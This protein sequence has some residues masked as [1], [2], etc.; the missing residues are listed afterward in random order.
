MLS[1]LCIG[2]W[3]YL[4]AVYLQCLFRSHPYFHYQ[5]F[6]MF[7]T[8]ELIVSMCTYASVIWG[9][10]LPVYS[11]RHSLIEF[12]SVST[13][14]H[15]DN[16]W[17]FVMLKSIGYFLYYIFSIFFCYLTEVYK[18]DMNPWPNSRRQNTLTKDPEDEEKN[19]GGTGE[20][21]FDCLISHF[22]TTVFLFGFV[23]FASL[24][25]PSQSLQSER[26]EEA[27]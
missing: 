21:G 9:A 24:F 4:I 12:F 14:R 27:S 22:L 3:F 2:S 25:T 16:N 11:S 5:C 18:S 19:R 20:S 15:R 7:I 1:I 13:C 17:W 23:C 6:G 26:L 8:F 10:W